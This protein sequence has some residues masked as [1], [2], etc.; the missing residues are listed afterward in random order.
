M[1][2][3]PLPLAGRLIVVTGAN[4]GIGRAT[5]LALAARGGDLMLACRSEER[6]APVVAAA[7]SAGRGKARFVPLDLGDFASVRRCAAR[8]EALGRP[9]DVLINNAGLAGQR[10]LTK[11]GFELAFGTNHLG[12][13][14]LTLLL[15]PCLSAGS[16]SRVVTVSSQAHADAKAIDFDAI[17]RPT[18]SITG[19]QEYCVSKLANVLFTRELARRIAPSSVR[20]YVLHP[21]VVA[22][23]IWRKV[24]WPIR[25]LMKRRMISNED[26]AKTTLYCA[27]SP[28]VARSNGR[29]YDDCREKT[30]SALAQDDDLAQRLW[31]KS[32]AF[33]GADWPRILR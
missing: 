31:A 18:R 27:T 1:D 25:P 19:L 8:I 11:D 5:A 17:R 12:H 10:G 2:G 16:A 22:S 20:S 33:T 28:D 29:H 3:Q 32:A 13:F 30:P 15:L 6:T 7:E 21:G 14:L 9:V 4:A 23:D 24:P 26:G